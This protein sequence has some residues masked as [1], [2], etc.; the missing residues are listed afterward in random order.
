MKQKSIWEMS[1][2]SALAELG[3]A[4]KEYGKNLIQLMV[5]PSHYLERV[6]YLSNVILARMRSKKPKHREGQ[7]VKN[8]RSVVSTDETT[9]IPANS[10]NRVQAIWWLKESNSFA[11]Q[12]EGVHGGNDITLFSANKF[13]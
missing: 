13:T 11:L 9:N 10:T 1:D 6:K 7:R 5:P 8:S 3:E 4:N 2:E 12:F